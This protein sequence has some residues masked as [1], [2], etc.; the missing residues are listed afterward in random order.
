MHHLWSPLAGSLHRWVTAVP[1]ILT[2]ATSDLI[3]CT[4]DSTV[5]VARGTTFFGERFPVTYILKVI[6]RSRYPL[7]KYHAI[8][9]QSKAIRHHKKQ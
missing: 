3:V 5:D 9:G 4:L 1:R 6:F 8:E 7:S 2:F